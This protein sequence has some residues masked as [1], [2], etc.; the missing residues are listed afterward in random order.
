M[1][2]DIWSLVAYIYKGHE[3]AQMDSS[4]L[5]CFLVGGAA[6]MLVSVLRL[7]TLNVKGKNVSAVIVL[8][9]LT[10]NTPPD[11]ESY[12]SPASSQ[13]YDQTED[14]QYSTHTATI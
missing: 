11:S 12:Y 14:P 7:T 1:L 10:G 9:E 2:G 4:Y 8:F 6:G 5:L 13:K 3:E